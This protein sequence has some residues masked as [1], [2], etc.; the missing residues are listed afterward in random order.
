VFTLGDDPA[1]QVVVTGSGLY[2]A[3]GSTIA[4]DITI[5]R[6]I[7]G[8]SGRFAGATG[9]AETEHLADDTWRHTLHFTSVGPGRGI[10]VLPERPRRDDRESRR[11]RRV[12]SRPEAAPEPSIVRTLLGQTEPTVAEGETL[13]LWQYVIPA[14]AELAPHTHPG[15]QVARIVSGMLTYE[16]VSG[17]A[18]VLRRDGASE[19]VGAG[20]SVTLVPGDTVVESPGM[21]HFASNAGRRPVV[22]ISATL[23]ETG[24]EPATPVE[25][26]A[27]PEST[28]PQGRCSP[29]GHLSPLQPDAVPRV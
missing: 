2:P 24:A 11:G 29:R 6:S 9:W 1:D 3:A 18:Q 13:G 4:V 27:E 15:D 12:P 20:S 5:V 8:G 10:G 22:I 25:R 14:G 21:V 23:F 28:A 19:T 7:V 17:E 16:V 26:P